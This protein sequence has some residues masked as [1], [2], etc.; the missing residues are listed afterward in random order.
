MDRHYDITLSTKQGCNNG[1]CLQIKARLVCTTN[2]L[3]TALGLRCGTLTLTTAG[4]RSDHAVLVTCLIKSQDS[5]VHHLKWCNTTWSHHLWRCLGLIPTP[6]PWSHSHTIRVISTSD[7]HILIVCTGRSI[8]SFSLCLKNLI[9]LSLLPALFLPLPQKLKG[10]VNAE[11]IINLD[12][13]SI[14]GKILKQ[15]CSWKDFVD[16]ILQ[17]TWCPVASC[18]YTKPHPCTT[19]F[20]G[21]SKVPHQS[22]TTKY[23]KPQRRKWFNN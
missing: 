13:I 3:G 20:V 23:S 18:V 4:E 14:L 1:G 8:Q 19:H 17:I 21:S 6:F 11:V 22:M 9:S 7:V 5:S 2:Y 12:M 10:E 16:S 15:A